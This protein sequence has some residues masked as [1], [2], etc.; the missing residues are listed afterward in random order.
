MK[1]I[2]KIFALCCFLV[3]A[4]CSNKEAS[5]QA[6][7]VI[8]IISDQWSTKVADG[9]G[10]YANGIQTPE[11]DHLAAAGIRFTQG[12]KYFSLVQNRIPS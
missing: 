4:S 8:L 5:D 11:I 1:T 9:S 3:V 6:P 2:Y 10:N 7:N 12:C